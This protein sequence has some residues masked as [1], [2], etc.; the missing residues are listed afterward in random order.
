MDT[1]LENGGQRR[2]H[3]RASDE[4]TF[5]LKKRAG[6]RELKFTIKKK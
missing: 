6:R 3:L 5:P 4:S 1:I 2:S